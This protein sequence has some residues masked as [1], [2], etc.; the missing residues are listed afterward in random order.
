MPGDVTVEGPDAGVVLL[1]LEDLVRWKGRELVFVVLVWGWVR[2][3]KGGWD[4]I[5]V[6]W[7]NVPHSHS[8]ARSARRDAQG[9]LG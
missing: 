1:P 3:C 5:A 7:M 4:R 2:E 6:V 9:Y 8:Q